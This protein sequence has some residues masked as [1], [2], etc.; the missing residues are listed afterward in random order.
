MNRGLDVLR[1]TL[2]IIFGRQ[3]TDYL[4][5]AIPQVSGAHQYSKIERDIIAR[6]AAVGA[7]VLGPIPAGHQRQFFCLDS[8][9]WIWNEQW[10]NS[11]GKQ[12]MYNVQYDVRPDGILKRVNNS[13]PIKL[14]DQELQNF[15]QAITRYYHEVSS[16]VYGRT[17][18]AA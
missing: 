1:R 15:D 9:T 13:S 12:C 14:G 6:E 17:V 11:E 2:D 4:M 3:V 5:G 7:S 18:A 8:H 16:K 10:I